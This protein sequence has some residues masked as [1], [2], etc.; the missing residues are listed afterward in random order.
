VHAERPFVVRRH[1]SDKWRGSSDGGTSKVAGMPMPIKAID[2][3]SDAT[4][5][6]FGKKFSTRS[7]KWQP[8]TPHLP[9]GATSGDVTSARRNN[10]YGRI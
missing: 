8:S 4:K 5:R 2:L 9:M 3:A 6:A 1:V 7:R 10:F